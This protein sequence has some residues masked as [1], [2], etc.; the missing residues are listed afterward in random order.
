MNVA[1]KKRKVLISCAIISQM[2]CAF[3]FAYVYAEGRCCH[4]A[5]HT[6]IHQCNI[7]PL[8]MEN[9]I[10]AKKNPYVLWVLVIAIL[11]GC[12]CVRV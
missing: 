10:F 1:K 3:V 5:A 12:R 2:I 11:D 7:L 9:D 8:K 6:L 4:V